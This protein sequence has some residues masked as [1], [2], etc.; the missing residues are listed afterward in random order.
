MR[1]GYAIVVKKQFD[2]IYY[3]NIFFYLFQ[4]ILIWYYVEYNTIESGYGE[5][6]PHG[7]CE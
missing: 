3:F 4:I 1:I 2:K 6:K 5:V 7:D